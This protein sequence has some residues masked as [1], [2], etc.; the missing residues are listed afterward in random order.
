MLG[1]LIYCLVVM[2]LVITV[3]VNFAWKAESA[4]KADKRVNITGTPGN[5]AKWITTTELGNSVIVEDAGGQVALG[6]TPISSAKFL[7]YGSFDISKT[8]IRG[9]NTGNGRGVEGTSTSGI[10]VNGKGRHNR[11]ERHH[12]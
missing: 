11:S 7:V 1:R 2:T 10:G 12:V 6:S 9:F 8:A 4:E 3:S 5:I